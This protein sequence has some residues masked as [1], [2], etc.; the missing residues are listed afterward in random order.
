[1]SWIN[2]RAAIST[3]IARMMM[4]RHRT[5][6]QAAAVSDAGHLPALVEARDLVPVPAAWPV[7]AS[8]LAIAHEVVRRGHDVEVRSDWV[9]SAR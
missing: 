2:A 7:G 4:Y 5:N 8:Q 6:G 1:M 3:Q 9:V